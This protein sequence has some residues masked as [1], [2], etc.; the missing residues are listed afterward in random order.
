MVPRVILFREEHSRRVLVPEVDFISA[1]GPDPEDPHRRGGP[2]ALVTEM[3]LFA[4]ERARGRFRLESVHPGHDLDEVIANTGFDFDRPASVP[5]TPLPD[6]ETLALIRGPVA[7]EI[8][9]TYPRF[10]ARLFPEA[11][12][13]AS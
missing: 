2:Q 12:A 8:A 11:V 9:R 4:F 7:C 13:T 3:A 5:E 10:A 1:A 6:A